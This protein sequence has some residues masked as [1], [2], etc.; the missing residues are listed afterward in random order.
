MTAKI[1]ML[2]IMT[3][4]AA[5]WVVRHIHISIVNRRGPFIRK[6]I[7]PASIENPP[8]VSIIVPARNEEHNIVKCLES[9]FAQDYPRLEVLVVND[10]SQDETASAVESFI[11]SQKGKSRIICSLIN[12]KELPDGWTGKT[13]ALHTGSRSAKGDWL[14]FVDADTRHDGSNVSQ[15]MEY[16]TREKVDMLSLIPGLE[17]RTFW[18]KTMQPLMGV[19]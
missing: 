12:I 2:I 14:L 15:A 13:F 5:V 4:I 8:F 9:I 19:Y 17:T 1:V 7:S 16:V 3:L 6:G 18:E 11:A 10:R